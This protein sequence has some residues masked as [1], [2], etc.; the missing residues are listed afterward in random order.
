MEPYLYLFT[1]TCFSWIPLWFKKTT[2][3]LSGI[4]DAN[5]ILLERMHRML[6]LCKCA[7]SFSTIIGWWISD[8]F[9]KGTEA[10]E[11]AHHSGLITSLEY[12]TLLQT[13]T[14]QVRFLPLCHCTCKFTSDSLRKRISLPKTLRC[15][16]LVH[17]ICSCQP[18]ISKPIPPYLSCLNKLIFS[19]C[20]VRN[21]PAGTY[22]LSKLRVLLKQR[23][24]LIVESIKFDNKP[25]WLYFYILEKQKGSPFHWLSKD[26]K[27]L[28]KALFSW[29]PT[30]WT[31]GLG[32]WDCSW[33]LYWVLMKKAGWLNS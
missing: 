33:V 17:E 18:P 19:H 31:Q 20:I 8:L 15:H 23:L 28:L 26:N 3:L 10:L 13:W 2:K 14:C 12:Y 30:A 6:T 11:P 21:P 4:I 32:K 25:N 7:S 5:F 29:V 9:L 1:S 16:H 22:Y 24:C 27:H